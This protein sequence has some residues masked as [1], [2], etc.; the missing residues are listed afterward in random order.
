MT[1]KTAKGPAD[2]ERQDR[3]S[4]PSHRASQKNRKIQ[5]GAGSGPFI[6]CSSLMNGLSRDG[7]NKAARSNKADHGG[8]DD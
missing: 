1:V 3:Q 8:R 2:A 7:R 4:M 6:D 5:P